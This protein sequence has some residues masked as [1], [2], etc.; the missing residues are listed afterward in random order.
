MMGDAK[1]IPRGGVVPRELLANPTA[2]QQLDHEPASDRRSERGEDGGHGVRV[3][4]GVVTQVNHYYF[5]GLTHSP[6]EFLERTSSLPET[7]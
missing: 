7:R 1:R 2:A 5:L 3:W 4:L 6:R